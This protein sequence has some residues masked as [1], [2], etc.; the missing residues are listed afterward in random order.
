MLGSRLPKSRRF[1]YEPRFYDPS[2]DAGEKRRI[3]FK[4]AY[5]KRQAKQRSL[6]WLFALLILVLY[7]LY[8]ISRIGR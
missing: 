8:V 7:A 2:K 3:E 5:R 6:I 4:R 1:N